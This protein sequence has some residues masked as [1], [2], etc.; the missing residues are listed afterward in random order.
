MKKKI[1]KKKYKPKGYWT[2]ENCLKDAKRFKYVRD[3]R[4]NSQGGYSAA[5]KRGWLKICCAHMQKL[6]SRFFRALYAFE[7][8]D[9]TVYVG[10]TLDYDARYSN[11]MRSSK[12]LI[13][14]RKMGGQVFVKF[15]TYYP[16][17][18]AGQKEEELIEKYRAE[19]WTIL[20]KSKAGALGGNSIKWTFKACMADAQK[21]EYS[22]DWERE[23][24]GA[25]HAA[26]RNGWLK[27][28]RKHM[29]ELTKPKKFYTKAEC[30]RIASKYGKRGEW[31]KGQPYSWGKARKMGWLDECCK[32]MEPS[33]TGRKQIV[34]VETREK[35]ESITSAS[36]KINLNKTKIGMVCRGLR[37]TTGGYTFKYVSKSETKE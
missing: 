33:R 4:N 34:C 27:E 3:W 18:I 24:R 5:H 14:K 28:C 21:Y 35:F 2:L 36:K 6:G 31:R 37:N 15:D 26:Q 11:H 23:S 32:H 29:K 25:H 1:K 19:G 8:P 30:K 16:K 22:A 20:N 12:F 17:N 7:H 9:K 10:L 13:Q